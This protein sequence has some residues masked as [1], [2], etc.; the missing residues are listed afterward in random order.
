MFYLLYRAGILACR[1]REQYSTERMVAFRIFDL[2]QEDQQTI[3]IIRF[4]HDLRQF[5]EQ[6]T[7]ERN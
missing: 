3:Q 1:K 6:R 2:R 7:E 5:A 4:L